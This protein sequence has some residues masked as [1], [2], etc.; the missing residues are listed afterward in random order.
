[1]LGLAFLLFGKWIPKVIAGVRTFCFFYINYMFYFVRMHSFTQP[2]NMLGE[3][4]RSQ[5]NK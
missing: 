4:S 2:L 3:L 1:M 5:Y